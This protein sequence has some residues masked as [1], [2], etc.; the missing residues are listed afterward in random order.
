MQKTQHSA[1]R[2]PLRA[3]DRSC[4]FTDSRTLYA[5]RIHRLAAAYFS[6]DQE[7]STY[8]NTTTACPLVQGGLRANRAKAG[9]GALGGEGS[10]RRFS[11]LASLHDELNSIFFGPSS[12][13]PLCLAAPSSVTTKLRGVAVYGSL[14]YS[15][16]ERERYL[17][18]RSGKCKSSSSAKSRSRNTSGTSL[19]P[20][21]WRKPLGRK[22]FR[23]RSRPSSSERM[24][25]LGDKSG[26]ENRKCEIPLNTWHL[27]WAK[28]EFALRRCGSCIR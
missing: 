18:N 2:R 9:F 27:C 6:S 23:R 12:S 26:V 28:R 22:S 1:S 24:N 19:S 25:D 3:Q 15:C 10:A 11:T 8:R 13:S 16:R 17:W 21:R 5:G 4:P 14:V 7:N 20:S